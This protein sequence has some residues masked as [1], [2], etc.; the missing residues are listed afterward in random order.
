MAIEKTGPM[1]WR[2]TGPHARRFAPL[3]LLGMLGFTVVAFMS[4]YFTVAGVAELTGIPFVLVLIAGLLLCGSVTINGRRM[5]LSPE[6]V[7]NVANIIAL[8]AATYHYLSQG[9]WPGYLLG[10]FAAMA[11]VSGYKKLARRKAVTRI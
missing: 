9:Q 3:F 10:F 11:V 8:F 2:L 7:A 6:P 1:K 5:G 4:A